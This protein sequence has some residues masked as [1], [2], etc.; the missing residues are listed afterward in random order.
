M[1]KGLLLINLGTPSNP[2]S[3]SV[4]RYLREFLADKRVIEL[5]AALRY[6]LLYGVILPF[7]T[8][9]TTHA[10]QAIWTKNG[11]PLRYLSELLRT[12][13]QNQLGEKYTVA[14]SM[15]YGEPNLL[16]A[17]NQLKS[18][19]EITVLPLY[20]QY[21]SAATGSSIEHVLHTIKSER[22]FPSLHILRD[23]YQHPAFIEAEV[24]LI[25][26]FLADHDHLLFSYHG[27]PERH[28]Q[29]SGCETVCTN[30]CPA[31]SQSNTN[32]A[33]YRAQCFQTSHLI[34]EQLQLTPNRFSTGFQSRLGRTPWITPYI[35]TLLPQLA[36]QGIK[37]LAVACPSFVTDCLETLEEIGMRA[38]IAWQKLGGEK[39]TLIPALND[40]DRWVDAIIR[41]ITK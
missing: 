28:I 22:I 37:R 35:D 6:L 19:E 25:R 27:L 7:R 2:D 4:R 33:C 30:A 15:R 36:Q 8:G 31:P 29:Q 32:L 12:K 16:N 24:E 17:L 41:I 13:L 3:T 39:L 38:G 26:P 14:L 5:P 9:K 40:N 10:Y 34:A 23:F 18:C 20:P 11:S 1:K 21:S